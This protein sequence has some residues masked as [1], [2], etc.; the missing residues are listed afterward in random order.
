M[1]REQEALVRRTRDGL[2]LLAERGERFSAKRAEDL[3]I[4][5]LEARAA[6]G[7]RADDDAAAS[8]ERLERARDARVGGA[9][10]L[11]YVRRDERTVRARVTR[12]ERRERIGLRAEER[13]G[14]ADGERHAE[15][16]AIARR[17]FHGDEA[18]LSCDPNADDAAIALELVDPRSAAALAALRDLARREIADRAEHV[19]ERVGARRGRLEALELPLVGLEQLVVEELA[20]LR[21]AE[22][23]AELGVVDRER[24]RAALGERRVAVV[25]EVRD[26]GEEQRRRE[27]GGRRRLELRRTDAPRLDLVEHVAERGHVEDVAQALSVSLEHDRKR[28]VARRHGQQIRRALSLR[29]ERRA[30]SGRAPRQEERAR[31]CLAK[32]RGEER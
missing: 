8:N 9:E 27:R 7:E 28:R 29:P 22:D 17:V 30:L 23:L 21:L 5:V 10:A 2:D 18:R 6:R 25:D 1:P 26:E 12:D 13:V 19:A 31:R 20:E 16:V 24:V 4:A 32:S 14:Q 3:A 11:G 15:R